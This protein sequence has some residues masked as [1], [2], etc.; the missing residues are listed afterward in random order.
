MSDAMATDNLMKIATA[1]LAFTE[2]RGADLPST[3]IRYQWFDGSLDEV[4]AALAT[5]QN[6]DGG[7]GNRLE[8]DIHALESNPF[9][10]RIAMQY[11]RLLPPD[12]APEMR[13]RLREWLVTN[14]HEDGDWH[15]SE[16]TK[17]GFLQPWFGAWE[18]PSLNPA[19]CVAGLAESLGLVSSGILLRTTT[20]F[21]EKASVEQV[22][23][24]G[25]YDLLPYVEY[26][27]GAQ[28]PD[29]YT[30]AISDSIV[31]RAKADEFENAEH[32]FTLAMG[33]SAEI[34]ARIPAEMISRYGE[35]LTA[36]QQEDGGWPTPYDDAWRVWTTANAMTILS[37]LSS[38]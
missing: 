21:A 2:S 17:A 6:D 23:S 3:L 26:S 18:F 4:I 36:E 10:A 16:A 12:T 13:S 19:C 29:E 9:A 11:L 27:L 37:R 31:R 30:D 34:A 28:L 33:G 15:F 20:L 38:A 25:F 32:F 1:T 8:P 22:S 24:G 14:Q 7:F 5:Y 35:Q